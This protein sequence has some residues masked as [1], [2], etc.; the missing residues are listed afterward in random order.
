MGPSAVFNQH[1]TK[2]I[3]IINQQIGQG[4]TL[5]LRGIWFLLNYDL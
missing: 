1:V 2:F 5:A 4:S 3:S